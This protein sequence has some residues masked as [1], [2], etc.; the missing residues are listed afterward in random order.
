MQALPVG[1]MVQGGAVSS[2]Q[3]RQQLHDMFQLVQSGV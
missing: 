3:A 1:R 2:V